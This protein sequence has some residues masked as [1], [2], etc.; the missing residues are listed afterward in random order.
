MNVHAEFIQAMQD[1]RICILKDKEGNT[2]VVQPY[3]IFLTHQTKVM[4]CCYQV[5]GYSGS[6]GVPNWRNFPIT[7]IES[8][9]IT[10][11]TFKKRDDFNPDNKSVY[12]R[13]AEK[14]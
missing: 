3:G 7:E 8:V 1:R 10:S 11:R 5:S 12:P 13:W 14:I 2:R 9:E 6:R 4:Y